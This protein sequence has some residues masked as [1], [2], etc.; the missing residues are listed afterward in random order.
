M[1]QRQLEPPTVLDGLAVGGIGDLYATKL[2]V[3]AGSGELRDYFD[4]MRIEQDTGRPIEEG[5]SLF[6][7][8][9]GVDETNPILNRLVAGLGYLD[10]LADDP[11]LVGE[12]GD[13]IV[14]DV[15]QYWATRQP[16]LI[17]N[18]DGG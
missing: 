1:N 2:N 13:A 14:D 17:R 6:M 12:F 7:A 15:K 11:Y 10:D 16:R 5:I 18:L 9:F 3:V 8:R 4:L